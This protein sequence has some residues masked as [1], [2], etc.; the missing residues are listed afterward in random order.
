MN[1]SSAFSA[2]IFLAIFSA[3]VAVAYFLYGVVVGRP[4]VAI[5]A[6]AAL[7]AALVSL[8]IKIADQWEKVVVLRLG[9]FRAL[10]GPGLFLVIPIVDAIPYW[11]DTRVITASSRR[12]RPSPRTPFR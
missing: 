3:G 12:R 8:S 5:G 10:K 2:L 6:G 1:K 9:K 4:S 7:V 11:I